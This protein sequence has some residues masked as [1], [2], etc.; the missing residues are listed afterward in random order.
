MKIKL[1]TYFFILL[2]FL[3]VTAFTTSQN[4]LSADIEKKAP[5]LHQPRLAVPIEPVETILNAFHSHS[6]VAIDGTA[7]GD[8]QFH[9]FLRSLISDPRFANTVNDIVVEW[10]NARYQG[11]VD[12]FVQGGNVS[13]DD[14]RQIWQN[15]T[16]PNYVWDSPVYEAFFQTVRKVNASLPKEKQLR[17]LLG[18][19][20]L[21]WNNIHSKKDLSDIMFKRNAYPAQLI[22]R[23]V[24]NQHRRA[25]IIYGGIHLQRKNI[26]SNYENG[27]EESETLINLLEKTNA[28]RVFTIWTAADLEKIQANIATWPTPSIAI[29]K[30][31]KLGVADFTW[32]YPYKISRGRV[33]DGQYIPIA[34]SQWRPKRMEDQF[35]AVMYAGSSFSITISHLST[36]TCSDTAY[37]QMR[38]SR[39][40]M[41][42]ASQSDVNKLKKN[43]AIAAK[44]PGKKESLKDY[45]RNENAVPDPTLAK[46][47]K[48]TK[49]L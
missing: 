25:L 41:S 47:R 40:L 43:C 11:L 8:E 31:T 7:H 9:A 18:D 45:L 48:I 28:T 20:P 32:Y 29:I 37:M 30:G 46:W 14:F 35:D 22:R 19:P 10:G 16:Q 13:H 24:L 49:Q 21:D 12:R 23:E 34:H 3:T 27:G 26:F 6:L 42:G 4:T 38:I 17:V 1:R 44:T 33:L 2:I 39:M 5:Q 15:T 36:S